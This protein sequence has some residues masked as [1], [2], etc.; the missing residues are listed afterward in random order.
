[1]LWEKLDETEL[2]KA[3]RTTNGVLQIVTEFL[4]MLPV[5]A[6]VKD[7]RGRL[8][9]LNAAA[10]RLW[11]TKAHTAIGKT[12]SQLA[13]WKCSDAVVRA[14]DRLVLLEQATHVVGSVNSMPHCFMLLF[15]VLDADG[16]ALIG[17]IA[18]QTHDG[19]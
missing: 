4:A 18:V 3:A 17:G 15:P 7:K 13:Y 14:G 5:P 8:I 16:D 2:A 12:F 9:F 6:F 10:E 1:M 11:K 19:K